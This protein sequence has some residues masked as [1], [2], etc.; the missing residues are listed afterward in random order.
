MKRILIIDDAAEITTSLEYLFNLEGFQVFTAFNAEDGIRIAKNEKPNIIICDL[1][2]PEKDGYYV[3]DELKKD[4]GTNSI[5]FII[6]TAR[7]EPDEIKKGYSVGASHFFV[8]PFSI[9]ELIKVI[10]N[11]LSATTV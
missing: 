10:D 7:S 6:I 3:I 11:I 4:S 9:K 1:M 5:P 8:K 2:M